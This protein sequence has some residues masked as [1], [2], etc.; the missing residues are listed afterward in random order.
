MQQ[1]GWEESYQLFW[2]A[3]HIASYLDEIAVGLH[4]VGA[5]EFLQNV[6][7]SLMEKLAI[8]LNRLSKTLP[9]FGQYYGRSFELWQ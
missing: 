5:S 2:S 1:V 8:F 4:E 9:Q 7:I 3:S 6:V